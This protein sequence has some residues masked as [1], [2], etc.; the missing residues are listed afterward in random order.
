MLTY[1]LKTNEPCKTETV[2]MAD[3]DILESHILYT[4]RFDTRV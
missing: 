2:T 3:Y 4:I 1:R